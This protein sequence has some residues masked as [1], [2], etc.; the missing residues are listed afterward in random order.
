M[1]QKTNRPKDRSP[2]D[3][4]EIQDRTS[5]LI[6]DAY[7]SDRP[8]LIES[9]PAGGKTTSALR[10][11]DSFDTPVTYLSARIDLYNQAKEICDEY[12]I[13]WELIPSPHR[14]CP[15]FRDEKTATQVIRLYRKGMSGR[16]IHY[17][18][19]GYTPCYE[20]CPYLN[21]LEGLAG[22]VNSVDVLIGHH[23]HINRE[24][25]IRNRIVIQDEFNIQ[26]FFE[27][28]PDKTTTVVD[29]PGKIIR[30]FLDKVHEADLGFPDELQ[31]LTDIIEYR[32][33]PE[34]ANEALD[35]FIEKGVSRKSVQ[36]RYDFLTP[37]SQ[38]YD[39]VHFKA[40]L[41]VFSLLCMERFGS[42]LEVSPPSTGELLEVWN[43]S[44]VSPGT[45]C[46]RNRDT[47][48]IHVLTPPDLSSASQIIGLDGIPTVELWEQLFS[49]ED[50]FEH[51]TVIPRSEYPHYLQSALN[52]DVIQLGDGMY[53]YAGGRVSPW[54]DYRLEYIRI[55]EAGDRFPLI[56]TRKA[57]LEYRQD[58]LLSTYVKRNDLSTDVLESDTLVDDDYLALHYSLIR[59]S[60]VF[61]EEELGAVFGSPLPSDDLV[62]ILAGLCG[63]YCI[64]ED[65]GD[66]KSFGEFGDK[67]YHH[68]C[69]DQVVQ[70]ILRFGRD[71]SVI[72]QGSTVYV[73]TLALPEWFQV[74]E[75][76]EFRRGDN[77][78]AVIEQLIKSARSED[79][80]P[81]GWERVGTIYT[82]LNPDPDDSD[83]EL[84]D[85]S[86]GQETEEEYKRSTIRL[87]LEQLVEDRLVETR[88]NSGK[89][90]ADLYRWIGDEYL[91]DSFDERYIMLF[92]GAIEILD[93]RDTD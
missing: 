87:Q 32:S 59:S 54:D 84:E 71:S 82:A 42:G 21:T 72:E 85:E 29:A 44:D 30:T 2:I 64:R 66:A 27:R 57:L 20:D 39:S 34:I 25:Y 65:D 77:R 83:E 24:D 51:H 48:T 41:L 6:S 69:H 80:P 1:G 55:N 23:S 26:P 11:A 15:T 38:Q 13:E 89:Y 81:S 68:L 12:G 63:H 43:Q 17:S 58:D 62:T 33:E 40:P 78:L 56:S 7:Q 8:T 73:S 18:E 45:K 47:G 50:G 46:M 19:A 67:I 36:E 93:V 92:D 76:V 75:T 5:Q 10:L 79:G 16:E 61:G 49:P 31:D 9:P 35:W 90:N 91:I 70:A 4:K 86:D 3:L 74:H 53:P 22:E 88:E 52:M 28:F 37:S 14:L 60:N